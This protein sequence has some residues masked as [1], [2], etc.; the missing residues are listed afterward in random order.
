MKNVLTCF[1]LIASP[2]FA[3]QSSVLHGRLI[4]A[5]LLP[6]VGTPIAISRIIDPLREPKGN[7]WSTSAVTDATGAFGSKG[8]R[9][10]SIGFA[11]NASF[12]NT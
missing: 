8:C 2:A 4:Q 10:E 12:R 9:L 3:Q 1:C 11:H 7:A 5:D 6:V